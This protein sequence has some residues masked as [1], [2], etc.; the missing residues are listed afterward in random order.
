MEN[1]KRDE[2]SVTTLLAISNVDE[3]TP[4]ALWADPTTHRLLT[5]PV[6]LI[7]YELLANKSTDVSADGSSDTKYP[8]V[9]AI[10]DYAD[11]LVVG[12]LDYRGAY[13]ASGDVFP[14]TGGSGTAGAVLKGDTWVISVGGTLG[15]TAVQVGDSLIANVDTPGQTAGSWNI[16][17]GNISYVPENVAN[18]VTSI[19]GSSTDT[20]YASAKLVFDQFA[21]KAPLAS[22]VFTTKIQ[23]PTIELGHASDTTIARSAAG[24]ISVEGIVI[25]S[26]SSANTLTNKRVTPRFS[27]EASA[28]E[29]TIN[30]DAV[31]AHSITALAAA[32]TSMTTNLTGTPT[33]F[34]KL[35]I[36]IKDNATPRAITWG[37][38]FEAK[39]V[40]LPTTTVTSKVLTVGFIYD[41][42]TSKWGCVAVSQEA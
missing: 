37:A 2:N 27:A 38:S 4:V 8:S 42:V 40:D 32:I 14:S 35:I 13:D 20:Q 15:G 11:G 5:S 24:V 41:T 21:L 16:L 23:T 25:P 34:D 17:N 39:G 1:A 30:T 22:P 12:L 33:N 36:R 7:N 29:P 6:N 10:K 3:V 28:A 26:I 19:S 31:D 18:K 9:K